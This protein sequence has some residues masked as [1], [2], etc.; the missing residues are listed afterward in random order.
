M[1]LGRSFTASRLAF[2]FG[3]RPVFPSVHD[4]RTAGTANVLQQSSV[5]G[6][7]QQ[8]L[9]ALQRRRDRLHACL[10]RIPWPP[11][12]HFV[13][14]GQRQELPVKVG[15]SLETKSGAVL[16][17]L[18]QQEL[19]YLSGFF[20][21]DGCV[22]ATGNRGSC[23]LQVGQAFDRGEALVRFHA[24]F[25][26]GIYHHCS[27][28]GSKKP[29]IIWVV[30]G[31]AGRKAAAQLALWPSLKQSQLMIAA[32]WEGFDTNRQELYMSLKRL[33]RHDHNPALLDCSWPYLAGFFDAEGY[34]HISARSVS[35]NLQLTQN[36]RI[37]LDRIRMFLHNE[38]LP[39]WGP[40]RS[41]NA[42][43]VMLCTTLAAS[44]KTLQKLLAAGLVVKRREA[45]LALTLTAENHM[46]LRDELS[47][48]SGNQS[49][50]KRLDDIGVARAV[51]I[52]RV[53]S[54]LFNA[55]RSGQSEQ[56][57]S[58][59]R[60]LKQLREEHV[61]QR[62]TSQIA[63]LRLDIRE[64]LKNTDGLKTQI[65]LLVVML[66]CIQC[67]HDK[68][69]ELDEAIHIL[70]RSE[71]VA[72][73]AC[74]QLARWSAK[75]SEATSVS[76]E[77]SISKRSHIGMV[78]LRSL[79][80]S[81]GL[82]RRLSLRPERWLQTGAAGGCSIL[83]HGQQRCDSGGPQKSSSEQQLERHKQRLKRLID[84]LYWLPVTNFAVDGTLHA[85][86]L[87][88]VGL[89]AVGLSGSSQRK[90]PQQ[91]LEY[92]AG[93]FDGDGCVTLLTNQSSCVLS[94]GQSYTGG[95]ILL[96]FQSAFGGAIYL[97]KP[98]RGLSKPSLQWIATGIIGK[99]AA[100]VLSQW[101]SFKL[102]QLRIAANWPACSQERARL[103]HEL[104]SLKTQH[105]N[106]DSLACSWSYLAGFFDAEGYI[107]IRA[108]SAS[109][110]LD[111]SQKTSAILVCAHKFLCSEGLTLWR[112]VPLPAGRPVH[113][114]A[115]SDSKVSRK[116]LDCML[117]AGLLVKKVQAQLALKLNPENYGQIRQSLTEL[118][119]NQSR[120]ARLAP[121]GVA[122]A[123]GIKRLGN[124]LHYARLTNR[125]EL[126]SSTQAQIDQLRGTG[127]RMKQRC[128]RLVG[129]L[130]KLEWPKISHITF[131]DQRYELPVSSKLLCEGSPPRKVSQAELEYLVGF[132]DGDGC[133]GVATD[134]SGGR[135]YVDKSS[136][137]PEAIMQF[138]E[139][140]GG[141]VGM[142][143]QGLGLIKPMIQWIL[144]GHAARTAAAAM[145]TV[146]G[147]KQ[148]QLQS[149]AN[150]PKVASERKCLQVELKRLKAN[151]P[152]SSRIRCTW[153]YLAGFFDVEGSITV[154]ARHASRTLRLPQLHRERSARQAIKVDI[155]VMMQ[156]AWRDIRAL[157]R[158]GGTP[159]MTSQ[160]IVTGIAVGITEH[161]YHYCGGSCS[162][163]AC[164][165]C[166]EGFQM[167][168]HVHDVQDAD[169][170]T[171]EEFRAKSAF[172]ANHIRGFA[173]GKFRKCDPE[174]AASAALMGLTLEVRSWLRSLKSQQSEGLAKQRDEA[175]QRSVNALRLMRDT[176]RD[177]QAA[178]VLEPAA[179]VPCDL[180]SRRWLDG[181]RPRVSGR[182]PPAKYKSKSRSRTD[183]TQGGL[184]ADASF[185]LLYGQGKGVASCAQAATQ[186]KGLQTECRTI[187]Q[188]VTQDTSALYYNKTTCKLCSPSSGAQVRRTLTTD[189][190][191]CQTMC[192]QDLGCRG[193]DHDASRDMCRLFGSCP[194]SARLDEFGCVWTIYDRPLSEVPTSKPGAGKQGN[195]TIV[196][197]AG[198][199]NN[200]STTT[201]RAQRGIAIAGGRPAAC[202][203]LVW[204]SLALVLATMV[205]R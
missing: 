162:G 178:P 40:V 87:K 174:H 104:K 78:S 57:L 132:F 76:T 153:P 63:S 98:G 141:G 1:Q 195:Q 114:L 24:A 185:C 187:G 142:K 179:S 190:I 166:T 81:H 9:D 126:A 122:R 140:F 68:L 60:Q 5:N 188:D 171:S 52:R 117:G 79:P 53:G 90:L 165:G 25:G 136:D 199:N 83:A 175:L 157:L 125:H 109:I 39:E 32:C 93:F 160:N 116:T 23:A 152:D 169:A 191:K 194:P 61:V 67:I 77:T 106:P 84:K 181:L 27:G 172:G 22:S 86:P 20:D 50:Y 75:A 193:F 158:Q 205:Q 164:S 173:G 139:A 62:L 54:R 100:E 182:V 36:N 133:A 85:L 180:G 177:M 48:L 123:I 13:A 148:P 15:T 14:F 8:S 33:K 107:F 46:A 92:L 112:H 82:M 184:E 124:K 59:Q 35:I 186:L 176:I 201:M 197:P 143:S 200:A 47:Q 203:P 147:I 49:K 167:Y 91:E 6:H 192:G 113:R 149:V 121:Q 71:K 119:G 101:P 37:V 19:E 110:V 155:V 72:A 144:S 74:G 120:Y 89:A 154:D 111:I 45:E 43:H 156:L 51:Q 38:K 103:A 150:W 145:A 42:S 29:S 102:P 202:C 55:R 70:D 128:D 12:K 80:L 131:H 17:N 118:S 7:Q 146:P 183:L 66:P 21:G 161:C 10:R 64:L 31:T 30:S 2:S 11:V 28:M 58:C 95:S 163:W 170:A 26:G 96:R 16:P 69:P 97:H 3:H 129:L 115:C 134:L 4:R 41:S 99:Q 18:S 94:I 88:P 73:S 168:A 138:Y 196:G 127:E 159:L 198:I 65:A 130:R 105:R 56:V 151:P 204:W 44:Q 135:L 189:V 137:R 108:C 34:V